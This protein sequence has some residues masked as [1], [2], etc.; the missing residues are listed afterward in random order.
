METPVSAPTSGAATA[1]FSPWKHQSV[2]VV[3]DEPGM[4]NFIQRA[5]ETRCDWIGTAG[6]VEAAEVLLARQH[7]DLIVL[8]ISL[9]GRSGVSWLQQLREQGYTGDVILMTA[10]A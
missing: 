6:S 1:D 4:V 10:Y 8:D 7:F 5:L 3:D 2:L 9:P